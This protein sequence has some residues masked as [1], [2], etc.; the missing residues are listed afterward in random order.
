[1]LQFYVYLRGITA[2]KL[3]EVKTGCPRKNGTRIKIMYY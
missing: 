3:F 1:M 2:S